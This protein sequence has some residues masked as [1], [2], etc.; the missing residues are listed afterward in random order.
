MKDCITLSSR[1]GSSTNLVKMKR[2]DGGESRTYL[3][4]FSSPIIN[5]GYT[6]D[7]KKFIDPG[8]GPMITE[9]C[10]LE[11]ADATV[12]SITYID[13]YGWIVTFY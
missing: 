5:T 6:E 9:G 1:E 11:E 12:R 4:K 3:V 8:G 10:Y 7:M 13:G 2:T